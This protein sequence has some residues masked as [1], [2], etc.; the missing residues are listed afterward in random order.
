MVDAHQI[1]LALHELRLVGVGDG[2]RGGVHVPVA[3][4]VALQ[5]DPVVLRLVEAVQVHL[6]NIGQVA[7]VERLV[8]GAA[9]GDVARV[10]RPA[11]GH[12]R[13]RAVVEPD[14]AVA[15]RRTEEVPAARAARQHLAGVG[16]DGVAGALQQADVLVDVYRHARARAFRGVVVGV[17]VHRGVARVARQHVVEA[18]VVVEHGAVGGGHA[19]GVGVFVHWEVAVDV[20]RTVVAAC[21]GAFPFGAAAPLLVQQ[22]QQRRAV[23]RVVVGPGI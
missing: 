15:Q 22:G 13:R 23:H 16:R 18:G 17:E 20:A 2:H 5:V 11:E 3:V 7:R 4:A 1:A 9:D 12:L 19:F 10:L 6:I 14:A 21:R 8:V